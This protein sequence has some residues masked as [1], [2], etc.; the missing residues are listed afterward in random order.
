MQ[1]VNRKRLKVPYTFF[2]NKYYILHIKSIF[3][4]FSTK[5]LKKQKN[6]IFSFI[7]SFAFCFIA[8]YVNLAYEELDSIAVKIIWYFKLYKWSQW[9]FRSYSKTALNCNS[10]LQ[11]MRKWK[12]SSLLTKNLLWETPLTM[13]WPLQ[14][15]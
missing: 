15:T 3:T 5:N 6:A 12:R 7:P 10:E 4:I 2:H 8:V 1:R 11:S 13:I 9:K 14:L